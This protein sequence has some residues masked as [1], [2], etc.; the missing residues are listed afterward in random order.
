M[1]FKINITDASITTVVAGS[2]GL[3]LVTF[4]DH[5]HVLGER[6]LLTNR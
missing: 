6:S 2:R 3:S 4:N 1:Q 5:A